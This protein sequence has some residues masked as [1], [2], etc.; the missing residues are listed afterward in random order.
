MGSAQ[1]IL[2]KYKGKYARK[3]TQDA[4]LAKVIHDKKTTEQEVRDRVVANDKAAQAKTT[5]HISHMENKVGSRADLMA[6]AQAKG[7]KYFRILSK[8]ELVKVLDPMTTG[9]N[10]DEIIRVAKER[11]QSGFGSKKKEPANVAA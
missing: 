1:E 4:K 10:Q 8:E 9:H 11:W 2:K 6:K 7:I 5:D 3:Q